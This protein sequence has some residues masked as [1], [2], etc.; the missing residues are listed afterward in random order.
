LLEQAMTAAAIHTAT[1]ARPTK[2][3]VRRA[4]M[5]VSFLCASALLFP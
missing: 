2:D 5:M 3:G 4:S 1:L